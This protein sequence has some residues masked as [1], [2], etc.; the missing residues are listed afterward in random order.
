MRMCAMI[1]SFTGPASRG[2]MMAFVW[3]G[4]MAV[5]RAHTPFDAVAGERPVLK[6]ERY[7]A[8]RT[9]SWGVFETRSGGPKEVLRGRTDG[10]LRG[11]VL[12]FE[13]DLRF[14]SRKKMHRSW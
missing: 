12:R 8:G 5:A 1:L 9:H 7:F 3:L 10:R 2:L 13:Q 14:S 11:D 4:G 6:L